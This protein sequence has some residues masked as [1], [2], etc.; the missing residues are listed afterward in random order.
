MCLVN[1]CCFH[2]GVETIPTVFEK[3][4]KS[5]G[6]WY[7]ASLKDKELAGQLKEEGTS[8][9]V[10]QH[11]KRTWR[12]PGHLVHNQVLKCLPAVLGNQQVALPF[13]PRH[14]AGMQ[15]HWSGM[16]RVQ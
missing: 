2:S 15:K 3:P 5:L 14:P 13:H 6:E 12:R 16:A 4:V 1:N 11:W 9:N 10:L 7:D 8:I